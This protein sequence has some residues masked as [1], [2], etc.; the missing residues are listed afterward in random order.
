M[1]E[2]IVANADRL[3]GGFSAGVYR[4][5]DGICHLEAFTPVNPAADEKLKALFPR[6]VADVEYLR[7]AHAGEVVAVADTE[8]EPDV[9]LMEIA[10]TRGFRSLL[11]APLMSKGLAIGVINVTRR[12]P[13]PFSAHHVE[14]LRTFADQAVIAIENTR[15][16]NEVQAKTRD[17]TEALEQQTA[18]SE[19]LEVISSSPGDLQPV[20]KSMLNNAL[21]ICEAKFGQL[22]LFDGRGFLAAE[23]HN[24]PAAYAELFKRGPLVPGPNTGLGRLIASKKVIHIPDVM[25]GNLYA[26][27]EPLRVATVEIL[28]AR[29]LLAVP[30]LKDPELVGSIIIYRQEVRPFSLRQIELVTNFAAQ[31]VI[32]IENTRLLKELR[33]RTDDLSESLHQQ[34][35]TADVLKVRRSICRL[36]CK[37][38]SSRRHCFAEQTRR[39]SCGR[40]TTS[41]SMRQ[42]ATAT[43]R[44][45]TSISAR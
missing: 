38:S 23:L 8:A 4:F 35:A 25:S 32:A 28:Q 31:A 39:K 6:P 29:T 1:F 14:L 13:G 40:V 15:L 34:T 22:L 18:T 12:N 27:R 20:F 11:Y 16:F 30:M 5:V 21:R 33:E 3:I 26:E 17:L 42:R 2:A 41:V 43:R 24:T 37:R 45:T 9:L 19:V 7:R 36:C 10:R 44:S